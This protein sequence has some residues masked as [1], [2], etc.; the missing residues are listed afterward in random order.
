MSIDAK[1]QA[2][3]PAC[4][5]PHA[6]ATVDG[7]KNMKN[8]AAD[9][10]IPPIAAATASS[11][12]RGYRHASTRVPAPAQLTLVRIARM[13]SVQ[14]TAAL[15]GLRPSQ[16]HSASATVPQIDGIGC[17]ARAAGSRTIAYGARVLRLSTVRTHRTERDRRRVP[18]R[19]RRLRQPQR[20]KRKQPHGTPRTRQ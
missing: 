20:R 11:E 14:H 2:R 18:V 19:I 4:Y 10:M 8:C 1:A 6:A 12:C 16:K 7:R 5:E 9:A 13:P 17:W 3:E 15:F